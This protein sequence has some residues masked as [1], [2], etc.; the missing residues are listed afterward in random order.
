LTVSDAL[1]EKRNTIVRERPGD[2]GVYELSK[3]VAS[4]ALFW[5][6]KLSAI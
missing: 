5:H 2:S 3:L 1:C 4:S 6:F